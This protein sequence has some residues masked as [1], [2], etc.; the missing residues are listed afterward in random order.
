MARGAETTEPDEVEPG[1]AV[2]MSEVEVEVSASTVVTGVVPAPE[3]D[4]EELVLLDEPPEDVTVVSLA[5]L[6][7]AAAPDDDVVVDP[8]G[9]D[10]PD[11]VEADAARRL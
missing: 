9:V 6:R 3:P 5:A 8:P 7:E 2:E 1:A 10:D 11:P 4:S